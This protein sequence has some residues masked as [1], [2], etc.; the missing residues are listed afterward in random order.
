MK[1][2]NEYL[3]AG[4]MIGMAFGLILSQAVIH[5]PVAEK[6]VIAQGWSSEQE[7]Q[8]A[9]AFAKADLYG[10]PVHLAARLK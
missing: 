10:I 9:L 3:V 6:P 5:L 7:R 1:K 8:G 4:L 2:Q